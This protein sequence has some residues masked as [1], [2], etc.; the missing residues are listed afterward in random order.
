MYRLFII[1]YYFFQESYSIIS[2]VKIMKKIIFNVYAAL[3]ASIAIFCAISMTEPGQSL[4]IPRDWVL[5]YYDNAALYIT[6][7]TLALLGLWVLSGKWKMWNRKLMVASSV[8]VLFTFWATMHAMPLA[9]PT[10]QFTAEFFTVE[11]ADQYI[12]DEDQ[13]VYVVEMNGEVRVFPRHHVQIPHVAGWQSE[14]TNYAITYCGLSN[15]A[16][17]I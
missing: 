10:Q 11:E 14:G 2:K 12:P 9:F 5:N 7:Q 6:L 3:L 4:N 16:M 1:S 8:G 17:V 15:L 13:R